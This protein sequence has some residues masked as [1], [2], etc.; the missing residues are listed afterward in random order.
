MLHGLGGFKVFYATQLFLTA[1]LGFPQVYR[2]LGVEPEFRSI[3]KQLGQAQ[4]HGRGNSAVFIQKL[5]YGLT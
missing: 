3:A 2:K 4:C 5:I 1:L